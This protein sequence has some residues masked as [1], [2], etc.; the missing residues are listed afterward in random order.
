MLIF[1]FLDKNQFG[2]SLRHCDDSL[3]V[4]DNFLATE[5]P[6]DL[7]VRGLGLNIKLC[8]V[9]LNTVDRLQFGGE[10]MRVGIN[11]REIVTTFNSVKRHIIIVM[12]VNVS[13]TVT[14]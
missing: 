3:A 2:I 6:G 13:D 8:S 7:S 12:N 5:V 9:L 4:H 11:L 10:G 1:K 14:E